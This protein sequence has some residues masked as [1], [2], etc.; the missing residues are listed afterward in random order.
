M[1]YKSNINTQVRGFYYAASGNDTFSGETLEVPKLTIQAAINAANALTPSPSAAN[2]ALVT[3]SQGGSFTTGFTLASF[4]QFNG[5]DTSIGTTTAFAVT[6]ASGLRCRLEAVSNAQASGTVFF[7]NGIS[8][9]ALFCGRCGITGANGIGVSLTGTLRDVFVNITALEIQA[10]GATGILITSTSVEPIDINV[11]TV[12]LEADNS[13]FVTKNT[14][15]IND[16]TVLS[17]SSV[18]TSTFTGTTAFNVQ[19]GILVVETAGDVNATAAIVVTAGGT[20]RITAGQLTGTIT[21]ATGGLLQI[22]AA[23]VTGNI[24]VD[25]GGMMEADI[26][27]HTGTVTNNGTL[28]GQ[29]N[30]VFYGNKNFLNQII[31]NELRARTETLEINNALAGP[32]GDIAI[33][34]SFGQITMDASTAFDLNAGTGNFR[35][36]TASTLGIHLRNTG[37]NTVPV[38]RTH[39]LGSNGAISSTFISAITPVGAVTGTP[40][41]TCIFVGGVA[42]TIFIHNGVSADNT[43]WVGSTGNVTGSALTDNFLVRGN[44][45]SAI[46]IG[47]ISMDS[48]GN[49]LRAG[50]G[51][52]LLP[53][54]SFTSDTASGMRLSA[55]N[56]VN[57]SA[58]GL[59]VLEL[60]A[61]ALSVGWLSVTAAAE[62]DPVTI[63]PLGV[64]DL[65]NPNVPLAINSLGT[66][67][68]RINNFSTAAD[69]F[70]GR[71]NQ[72]HISSNGG[73][74]IGPGTSVPGSTDGEVLTLRS[75]SPATKTKIK[76][77]SPNLAATFLELGI[78]NTGVNNSDAFITTTDTEL[79]LSTSAGEAIG[80]SSLNVTMN[81]DL[82]VD[83]NTLIVDSTNN[84]VSTGN[85]ATA[86]TDVT[87][88]QNSVNS[89]KGLTFSGT[90]ASGNSSTT[91]GITIQAGFLAASNT[92]LWV[93]NTG[94]LGDSSKNSFRYIVGSDVP[95]IVGVNN[96]GTLNKSLA[97][98]LNA[99]GAHCGFGFPTSVAQSAIQAQVHISTGTAA[100]I[101][102]IVQQSGGQTANL[103]EIRNSG[104][105]AISVIDAS[106]NWGIG[107]TLPDTKLHAL[108]TAAD[109]TAVTTT[110]TTGTNLGETAK[111]VGNRD[112]D[113]NVTASGGA[114][115]YRDS[116]DTSGTYESREATTGTTWF[117]RAV[118]PSRIIEINTAAEFEAL[119]SGGIVTVTSNI[120]LDMKVNVITSTRFVLSGASALLHLIGGDRGEVGFT[121]TGTGTFISGTGSFR[122]EQGIVFTSGSTGT[123]LGLTGTAVQQLVMKNIGFTAWT[124]LGSYTGGSIVFIID[125]P[126][127]ATA[128]YTGMTFIDCPVVGVFNFATFGFPIAAVLFTLDSKVQTA[129]T[130]AAIPVT[131]QATGS[132]LDFPTNTKNTSLIAVDRIDTATVGSVFKSKTGTDATI[133]SV[134]DG[135]IANGTITAQADNSAGGTT[136]SST[137][138]YFENEEITITGTTSYNG[139]FQIFNVVAGVS[140]DTITTF[141]ANDATGTVATVRLTITLAGGHG[142]VAGDDLKII[143]TNFYNGFETALNVATNDLTVN[144]TFVSTNT[145]SIERNLSL[146]QTDKRI[147]ATRNPGVADSK[148]IACTHVNDNS[149]ANGTIIN[150]VFTDMVFGTAASA[151]ISSSTMQRWKLVSELNGTFEFIDNFPFDGLITFDFTVTSSGGT[152]NF[153]FKWVKSISATITAS[154]IAFV[155]SNP[156]TITDSG[157]GFLTAGFKAEDTIIVS[158]SASNNINATIA[159]VVAG[160][161]T[162]VASD[163]LTVEAAGATVTINGLFGNLDDPVESLV[164]VGSDA[165]SVT[166]TFPLGV[167]TGIQIKP[168]IT[169]DSGT[170][171]VTTS[172]A[173]IYATD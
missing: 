83:T 90:S 5:E 118:N 95:L 22:T 142:I 159:S 127:I 73:T 61:P 53:T 14:P 71:S 67:S 40:G 161:I 165:Q 99:A 47:S 41:D 102:L 17:V 155:D 154:T 123:F 20:L 12:G 137:T 104:G 98:G 11:D 49:L 35:L 52:E 168:Q 151:L 136:H 43:S 34:S 91:E 147:L 116:A 128:S 139:S 29:I 76:I 33:Q 72:V 32:N 79:V 145:G 144:G 160:T 103:V 133:N 113:G 46:D 51:T 45:S 63:S 134:A 66:E 30:A 105:T 56:I 129:A 138:T 37:A 121:Y 9:S 62:N 163:A 120:A 16:L 68:L 4:I 117:K 125:V 70:L 24:T 126:L 169:R 86:L 38:V 65:S 149:T 89:L 150:N 158:G 143:A 115:Y 157:N 101:G 50:S 106:D 19:R 132:V 87:I 92:Q 170:S 156:D 146:D 153:R 6:L 131:Q 130:F 57:F 23:Q 74:G 111:F 122:A 166:K 28:T 39:S 167:A 15:G 164:A 135:T 172:F 100:I 26:I 13:T 148:S 82:T 21:V 48:G 8:D 36:T 55:T 31:G 84:R 44:G 119:A 64:D 97:F 141:V 75:E 124:A 171:A 173:T 3:G 114:E 85:I 88:F 2:I 109:T 59:D 42:S 81:A 25:S 107:T 77:Q 78:N 7:L 108:S 54:Y 58:R 152:V 69:I 94:D 27:S 18:D 96:I 93:C 110:E 1:S 162:L 10:T 140:F 80:I 112:P 60:T